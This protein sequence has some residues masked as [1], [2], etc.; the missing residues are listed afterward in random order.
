MDEPLTILN[1]MKKDHPK[2]KNYY[3]FDPIGRMETD[4][5]YYSEIDLFIGAHLNIFGREIV[6]TNLDEFT[7][8][9]YK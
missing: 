2:A 1:I 4:S 8:Q 7:K 3:V 5:N 6:I 9:Y